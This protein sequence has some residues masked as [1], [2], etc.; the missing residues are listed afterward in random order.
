M[1]TNLLLVATA[2]SLLSVMPAD[3]A[4]TVIGRGSAVAC[5]DAAQKAGRGIL[6][7]VQQTDAL[8]SCNAALAEKPVA[9]DITATLIN[10]GVVKGAMGRY[11]EA[12]ADYEAALTRQP[13]NAG[14]YLNR[15]LAYSGEGRY[16]LAKADFDHA[17]TLGTAD[18]HLAYF[19]RGAAQEKSGNLKAAYLDYRQALA[20]NPEF[21]PAKRE[22]ARFHVIE[23]RVADNR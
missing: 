6:P 12:I 23:R 18:A 1:K 7:A 2:L 16:D 20:I 9:V 21:E 15:G 4:T 13:G 14:A 22:L 11:D 5:F 17:L 8:A 19:D 10:R 3:A